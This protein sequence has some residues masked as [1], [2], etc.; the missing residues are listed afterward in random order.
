[1]NK[2]SRFILENLAL[3]AAG[4]NKFPPYSLWRDREV[5][6]INYGYLPTKASIVDS[7]D[8]DVTTM[9]DQELEDIVRTNALGRPMTA[10]LRLQ[11]EESGATEWLLPMEPMISINGQNILTR[12]K[13]NK[14]KIRGS[15]KERWAQDDYTVTIEGILMSND[16]SYPK[17]DI[18]KLRSFCEAGHIKV[19]SPLLEIF[20]ISQIAIESWQIPFTSGLTNQNYTITAYSDDIYKLLLSRDDLKV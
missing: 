16:G 13:V 17:D 15:I 11:K 18:A 20:D 6:G 19:L 14:G 4:L 10:P 9:T 2:A 1:M 12:R 5:N 8:F 3:R 7:K